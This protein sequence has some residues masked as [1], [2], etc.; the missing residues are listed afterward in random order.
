MKNTIVRSMLVLLV[1]GALLSACR[2]QPTD[3]SAHQK[4]EAAKSHQELST[5]VEKQR[6][7]D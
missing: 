6:K 7:S 4:S 3:T 2:S 5:E 1:S